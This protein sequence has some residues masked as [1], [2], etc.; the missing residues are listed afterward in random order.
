MALLSV[1]FWLGC[2]AGLLAGW[3][4]LVRR[5]LALEPEPDAVHFVETRDG[6]RLGLARYRPT[7]PR[8]GTPPVVLCPGW[9]L[10]GLVFDAGAECS[11]ARSLTRR[12]HD[13]WVLDPRGR[14]WSLGPRGSG[15]HRRVWTLDDLVDFDVPAAV[16]GV[17]R[18]TGA[19][20]LHW[21]GLGVGALVALAAA[22]AGGAAVGTG[23][24][25][26]G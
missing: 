3:T 17:L 8:P 23:S 9:G 16:E 12:G 24:S 6:W 13:V 11:L 26:R 5:L 19:P 4:W 2:L 10:S 20:A 21:V 14:G 18:E 7:T 25:R 22:G 1:F 15:R